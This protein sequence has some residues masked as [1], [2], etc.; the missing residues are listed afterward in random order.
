[1]LKFI[2]IL[3]LETAN[4]LLFY[5]AINFHKNIDISLEDVC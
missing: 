4:D 2:D 3:N 1:M 5:C